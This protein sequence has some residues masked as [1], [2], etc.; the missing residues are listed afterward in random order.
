MQLT[1]DDIFKLESRAVKDVRADYDSAKADYKA[2]DPDDSVYEY[3]NARY[4]NMKKIVD[5]VEC[6]GAYYCRH[7][8]LY[9][10]DEKE[11]LNRCNGQKEC[12]H[13]TCASKILAN[14]Y[15]NKKD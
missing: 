3:V 8:N 1:D 5:A 10:Y 9:C 7:T 14:H 15:L 13:A 6:D 12:P 4:F 2:V 11:F